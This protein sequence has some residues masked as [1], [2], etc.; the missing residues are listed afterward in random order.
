MPKIMQ[1]TCLSK[2]E[3]TMGQKIDGNILH[4]PSI[5]SE[6]AEALRSTY[7]ANSTACEVFSFYGSP[8]LPSLF[9]PHSILPGPS[10]ISL[11]DLVR[12]EMWNCQWKRV[13]PVHNVH[14]SLAYL[15]QAVCALRIDSDSSLSLTL[16]LI[17]LL[18]YTVAPTRI[19][20]TVSRYIP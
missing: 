14:H 18:D 10:S 2:A 19:E 12:R 20:V 9:P 17:M 5:T 6:S 4:K 1:S 16:L 7:L 13:Q 8:I 15:R 3:I 11:V